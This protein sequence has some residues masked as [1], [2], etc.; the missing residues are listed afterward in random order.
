M[1]QAFP[2]ISTEEAEVHI[3]GKER[4]AELR[5]ALA[6]FDHRTLASAGVNFCSR[7]MLYLAC[8]WGVLVL[9]SDLLRLGAS[10]FLGLFSGNLFMFG[11]DACHGSYVRSPRLNRI[12]GR[13]AFLP[14][15][16]SYSLWEYFHNRV[17]HPYTN[18]RTKDWVWV[19]LSK[20]EYDRLSPSARLMQRMYRSTPGLALYYFNEVWRVKMVLP[21]RRLLKRI[22]RIHWLD[23]WLVTG[24]VLLQLGVLVWVAT[25][26]HPHR[27]ADPVDWLKGLFYLYLLPFAIFNWLIGFVVYFNHTHPDIPWFAREE[28]WNFYR[29]TI[30]GT[31]GVRFPR[32]ARWFSAEI[33]HHTAHHLRV[34]IPLAN[35][36]AAQRKLEGLLGDEAM[37]VDWNFRNHH[38]ILSQCKLYDYEAHAWRDFSGRV[39]SRTPRSRAKWKVV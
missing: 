7:V 39:A 27:Y 8:F 22:R 35:L 38:K 17:H 26:T 10:F 23:A 36:G 33:M 34:G 32:W 24:Y 18:L 4:T 19:P 5:E 12:L 16:H 2:S 28:E 14:S 37:V 21:N 15:Y 29:G 6:E 3:I 9:E 11:H 30:H 25:V 20:E 13:I 31:V 1:K